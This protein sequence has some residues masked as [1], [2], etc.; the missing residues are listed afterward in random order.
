MT[1]Q[2]VVTTIAVSNE[3]DYLCSGLLFHSTDASVD[4]NDTDIIKQLCCNPTVMQLF[5][6]G[7]IIHTPKKLKTDNTLL[8]EWFDRFNQLELNST[9]SF[10]TVYTKEGKLKHLPNLEDVYYECTKPIKAMLGCS[11]CLNREISNDDCPW[12]KAQGGIKLNRNDDH[13]LNAWDLFKNRKTKIGPFTFISP[14]LTTPKYFSKT[15]RPYDE[16]D[17]EMITSVSK[18]R[19]KGMKERW[20][21]IKFKKHVCKECSIQKGCNAHYRNKYDYWNIQGCKGAYKKEIHNEILRNKKTQLTQKQ[22][23]QLLYC[24]GEL[25]KRYNRCKYFGTLTMVGNE[26]VYGLNHVNSYTSSYIFRTFKEASEILQTYMPNT[27]KKSCDWV[28]HNK[29][30]NKNI[31][32]KIITAIVESASLNYSPRLING[33]RITSYKVLYINLVKYSWPCKSPTIDIHFTWGRS[34]NGSVTLPW[35]LNIRTIDDIYENYGTLHTAEK[36]ESMLNYLTYH[37]H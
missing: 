28:E 11:E 35:N 26:L 21:L 37:N 15:K 2:N 27:W 23:L 33:W 29:I 24:G 12:K 13:Y 7:I 1:P 36:Q 3:E 22:I 8:M 9:E 16:H 32:N 31:S 25:E 14:A 10:V 4:L 6:N 5:P 20:R 19:S 18:D 17:F 30:S 34:K